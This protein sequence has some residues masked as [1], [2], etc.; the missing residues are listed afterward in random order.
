MTHKD[1]EDGSHPIGARWQAR[2]V[3]LAHW[4][5]ALL[6]NR[7]DIHGG[8]YVLKSGEIRRTTRHDDLTRDHLVRH[9][10]AADACDV[11]GLHATA[12]DETCRW[13]GVDID[14]HE[15]RGASYQANFRFAR[16]I[17]NRLA[18]IGLASRLLDSSGGRGGFHLWVVFDRPIPMVD[19]RRLALWL[20]RDWQDHDLPLRPDLFPGNRLLTGARCGNW[21]R[22]PGRHHKRGSWVTV[23]SSQRKDWLAGDAAI[24][25]LLTL[26]G[27]PADVTA[28][29]PAD[30]DIATAREPS[31]TA[32][33]N[34][35]SRPVT[36]MA[37][38]RPAP[39]IPGQ[40]R[41]AGSGPRELDLARRALEVYGN[42]DLDYDEWL[43]VG[44]ALRNLE[45]EEAAFELFD[46]WSA[47][48]DKYDSELTKA[49]WWSFRP[50][51]G[52]GGITLGTLFGRAMKLGWPGPAYFESVDSQGLRRIIHRSARR[53][54]VIIPLY[55]VAAAKP[56][57]AEDLLDDD[58]DPEA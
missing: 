12:P 57:P 8:Q 38:P 39:I 37:S 10:A 18:Q 20:V 6:V 35:P 53:G 44:M 27:K 14:A 7:R 16:V 50:A 51:D 11:I 47:S 32:Q 19:S 45:D 34:A 54:R 46:T 2:A 1:L 33:R 4:A 58:L 24:D 56:K 55:R 36:G 43:A 9:F 26:V 42:A 49:K 15:G 31:G 41:R 25:G 13:I 28:I 17:R 30:F 5:E 48:S 21:L 3:E 52:V 22:L 29:V 40:H 23:W